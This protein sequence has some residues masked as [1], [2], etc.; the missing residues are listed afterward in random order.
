MVNAHKIEKNLRSGNVDAAQLFAVSNIK[1]MADLLGV[2]ESWGR[3]YYNLVKNHK[4]IQ[5]D[6]AQSSGA[7]VRAAEALK[8]MDK[9]SVRR[10]LYELQR[11]FYQRYFEIVLSSLNTSVGRHS[12]PPYAAVLTAAEVN[13]VLK[14]SLDRIAELAKEEESR[15]GKEVTAACLDK[16]RALKERWSCL[17]NLP[18]P[19]VIVNVQPI[20]NT[21]F[22]LRRTT[23]T[24]CDA[25]PLGSTGGCDPD[26]ER[27]E[28]LGAM[29]KILNVFFQRQMKRVTK[30]VN[31]ALNPQSL[32]LSVEKFPLP[33]N[34]DMLAAG[35]ERAALTFG[36]I[37]K[38][39][40]ALNKAKEY[41][42]EMKEGKKP[43]E[44]NGVPI[45]QSDYVIDFLRC[46]IEVEDPYLVAVIF[47]VLLKAKIATC[48]RIC[49]VKNK[50]VDENLPKHIQTN[51]LMNLLLIYPQT[52][53]E[54][55]TSGLMGEFDPSMADKCMMV[56]ELQITMK[57][58]LTIKRLQHSYYDITRAGPAGLP[59]HLLTNGAF[60]N[61]ENLEWKVPS[62]VREL[63]RKSD[64]NSG[65]VKDERKNTNGDI[66]KL[67]LKIKELNLENEKLETENMENDKVENDKVEN[68]KLQN[69]K[70]ENE[71]NKIKLENEKLK[72]E[73]KKLNLENYKLK[74][75]NYKQNVKL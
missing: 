12:S 55:A 66:E 10:E 61:P 39:A 65:A 15:L 40:R 41:E 75:E 73:N 3:F 56:C 42:Q 69:E 25:S 7:A 38:A 54:F 70:V 35:G 30:A 47:F 51:V 9:P 43:N 8:K 52:D 23:S 16:Y 26:L 57:D 71:N 19:I 59:H 17:E 21:S 48:L 44:V 20:A 29:S 32:G 27:L 14:E 46:T 68:M 13:A 37:K 36:P 63:A 11:K 2:H 18:L 4:A 34:N 53:V 64:E 58:F 49:R 62:V 33:F 67:E 28:H 72:I 22:G 6:R 5:D 74:I 60:I 50:F 45:S 24:M 1:D 31:K